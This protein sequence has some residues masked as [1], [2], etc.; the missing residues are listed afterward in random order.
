MSEDIKLDV[1]D[2]DY[3]GMGLPVLE[4]FDEGEFVFASRIKFKRSYVTDSKDRT[5]YTHYTQIYD[6]KLD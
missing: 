5:M 6:D 4:T 1:F 3:D 2:I